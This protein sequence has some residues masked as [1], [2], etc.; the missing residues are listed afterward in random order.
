MA[1]DQTH[2]D[3][4]IPLTQTA[5]SKKPIFDVEAIYGI[6][7]RDLKK[8]WRERSR[9]FGGIA[10]PILWLLILGSSLKPAIS[11]STLGTPGV[12]YQQYIFPGVIA[13]TLIFAALQSAM[14]II[15]DRE[16]GFLKEVLASPVDRTA[17]VIGKGLGGATQAT[18]QGIIT[19]AFAPL[20][21]LWPSPI[22]IISLIL[23]MFLCGFALTSLG[24]VIASKMSSFEGF[25]TISNF[26]VMPMYF[27]SG[28][29]YPTT[30]VPDWIKPLIILNPLSYGVDALRYIVIGT[31][32]F[33]FIF[34]V[35][36]LVVFAVLMSLIAR[37]LFMQKE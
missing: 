37:F 4:L 16:F 1:I 14:S 6:W 28:A 34:D 27:L 7:L 10:R 18:L 3:V 15:W 13:L 21:G 33:P 5:K 35:G 11:E 17:I 30:S 32:T 12:D 2:V 19:L 20:I 36:Y 24:V 23:M 29:I 8:F 9:L 26:V 31:G 22:T 25:G